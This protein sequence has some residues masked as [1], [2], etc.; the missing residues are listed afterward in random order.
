MS[1]YHKIVTVYERDPATKFRTLIEGQWATPE[2]AYLKD[3]EWVWTEKLDGTNIRIKWDGEKVEFGGKTDNAQL[4]A[5]LVAWMNGKFYSG[6]LAR[7]LTG[8][9]VLY[10]EGFGAGIQ[11]GSKYRKDTV[12]VLFDVFCGGLWLRREDVDDIAKKLEIESVPVVSRG[13]LSN[14]VELARMGFPSNFGEFQP[15]GLVMRPAVEMLDRRGHRIITKI[16]AKDFSHG[17][18]R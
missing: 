10:G 6:A 14:A 13:P 5:P 15:E 4:Y 12:V 9:A 16:K 11:G 3:N 2:F 1:E 18:A 7:V 17:T 8:P